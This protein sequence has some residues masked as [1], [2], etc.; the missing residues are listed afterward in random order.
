MTLTVRQNDQGFA[1]EIANLSLWDEIDAETARTLSGLLGEHGVLVFRRQALSEPE[2]VRV[3]AMFGK[4]EPSIR[5]DWA[6]KYTRD[7]GYISNMR[8]PSGKPIGGLGSNEVVWHTDQ[9]YLPNPVTGA[10]L[11]CVETPPKSGR[12]SWSHMVLAYEAL[13]ETLKQ[14]IENFMTIFSYEKR[15]ATYEEKSRPGADL[16]KITPPVEHRLVNRHP[17]T[18]R[19]ALY[20]DPAT[21][22]GIAGLPQADSDALLGE[23]YER[24]TEARF[25]YIHEWSPGDLI[26]WD[27]AQTLHRREPIDESQSRL[28]KRMQFRIREGTSFRPRGRQIEH[29]K[30]V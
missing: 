12:T 15:S 26:V 11:Y 21:A 19:K 6:S 8:D 17:R 5:Y 24:A 2:L 16:R 9:S 1:R 10:M 29:A 3:A 27:N 4:L 20:L 14:R 7:V 25:Q 30:P 22:V 13:P 18:G 28:L 23:I